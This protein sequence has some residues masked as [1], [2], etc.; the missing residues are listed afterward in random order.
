MLV[1]CYNEPIMDI[2]LKKGLCLCRLE[3]T[4]DYIAISYQNIKWISDEL[5]KEEKSGKQ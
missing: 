4:S 1:T 2:K 3:N 5:L